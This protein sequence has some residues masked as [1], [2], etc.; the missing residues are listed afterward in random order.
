MSVYDFGI[1]FYEVPS[2]GSTFLWTERHTKAC[3]S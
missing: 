1:T 2:V 3:L